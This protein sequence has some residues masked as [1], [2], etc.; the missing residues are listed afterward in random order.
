MPQP[1]ANTYTADSSATRLRSST[2]GVACSGRMKVTGHYRG[3]RRSELL[4]EGGSLL[5]WPRPE[6]RHGV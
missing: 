3:G 1:I 2:T 4:A 6:R 5:E